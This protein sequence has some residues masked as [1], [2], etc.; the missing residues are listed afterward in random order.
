MKKRSVV[1]STM[2]TMAII[3][4]A[5]NAP[6]TLYSGSVSNMGI[7]DQAA[8]D[9]APVRGISNAWG[10]YTSRPSNPAPDRGVMLSW[11]V[12]SVG[13][14]WQYTYTMDGAIHGTD[15]WVNNIAIETPSSFQASDVLSGW[16]LI[17]TEADVP[18]Q[19][20]PVANIV[21]VDVTSITTGPSAAAP[22][23]GA[24][25]PLYNPALPTTIMTGIQ[26]STPTAPTFVVKDMVANM[27]VL[28]FISDYAPMWGDFLITSGASAGAGGP[29]VVN[30]K[31]GIDTSAPIAD[32]N[33]G[34][35]MLVPGV[36]AAPVPIPAPFLLFG[37]GL[38]GLGFLRRRFFS[39]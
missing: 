16:K 5:T 17:R 22:L 15:K 20:T 12:E 2:A 10:Q 35:W 19:P 39:L 11:T 31:F 18:T 24:S 23:T 33:N 21:P 3:L 4:F 6:A 28:T 37:S 26:W 36:K 1:F 7:T 38:A 25:L 34:G 9:A 32:G 14:Y 29:T 30:A 8:V 13:N 27:F